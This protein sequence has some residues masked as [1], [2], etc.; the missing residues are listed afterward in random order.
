MTVCTLASDSKKS[1]AWGIAFLGVELGDVDEDGAEE[2]VVLEEQGDGQ[3]VS[4]W[5][6]QGWNFSL[7][8]RSENGRFRNLTLR[9]G[10][11]N[12]LLLTVTP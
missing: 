6:W 12:Q 5:R 7:L 10:T 9:S 11:D 8:W 1:A 2:L 3:T 4:V